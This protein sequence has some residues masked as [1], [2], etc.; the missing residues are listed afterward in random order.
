MNRYRFTQPTKDYRPVTWPLPAG[1]AYWCSGYRGATLDGYRDEAAIIVAY[2]ADEAELLKFWPEAEDI[3]MHREDC[4]V[5]FTGRFPRPEW[6]EEATLCQRCQKAPPSSRLAKYCPPCRR[7]VQV[8]SGRRIGKRNSARGIGR[9][10]VE[11]RKE[12]DRG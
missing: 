12:A 5:T 8:E 7:E 3:D 4:E 6:Y 2:L 1:R 11:S 10:H 9:I